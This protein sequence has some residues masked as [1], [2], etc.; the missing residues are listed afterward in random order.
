M[1]CLLFAGLVLLFR[2]LSCTVQ[3][4]QPKAANRYQRQPQ[5]RILTVAC[6]GQFV[7]DD[8]AAAVAPVGYSFVDALR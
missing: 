4:E 5:N 7:I 6:F 3:E 8:R 2:A 1:A